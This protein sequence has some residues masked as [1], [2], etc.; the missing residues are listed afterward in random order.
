[1]ADRF[2]VGGS[3]T[4]NSTATAVWSTTSGGAGGASV[5][6]AADNAIFNAASGNV[7]VQANGT[8]LPCLNLDFRDFV[9]SF[10]P[11]GPGSGGTVRTSG[12]VYLSNTMRAFGNSTG[13]GNIAFGSSGTFFTNGVTIA[14]TL[15]VGNASANYIFNGNID[16][17]DL[18]RILGTGGNVTI[19]DTSIVLRPG[20]FLDWT[21]TGGPRTMVFTNNSITLA[22]GA[23][24]RFTGANINANLTGTT[25]VSNGGSLVVNTGVTAN[26]TTTSISV[27]GGSIDLRA[28]VL[29]GTPNVNI[30][31]YSNNM[32]ATTIAGNL[33]K[34]V[35]QSNAAL[36]ITST[37]NIA[38][39]EV[40]GGTLSLL[41]LSAANTFRIANLTMIGNGINNMSYLFGTPLTND[42]IRSGINTSSANI[43]W[44]VIKNIM[45]TS[46]VTANNSIA[47]G[48][49]A[50]VTVTVPSALNFN[51][52]RRK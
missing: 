33:N 51:P 26:F 37:A 31:P 21:A 30:T 29:S 45:F 32:A 38:T 16:L 48:N 36:E 43:S 8:S 46:A 49:I 17:F 41:T 18:K 44:T 20:A 34:A 2:W 1:M 7:N 4:W 28:A 19:K 3:A 14:T 15:I 11:R 25:I 10:V 23:T 12:N 40:Y 35:V 13:L 9:G 22:N 42:R 50:N 27:A 5:P 47:T 52:V 24:L 6:T 39:V